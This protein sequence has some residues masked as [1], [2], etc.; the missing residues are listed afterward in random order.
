MRA[1]LLVAVGLMLP[2]AVQ[3]NCS[4]AHPP[5]MNLGTYQGTVSNSGASNLTVNCTRNSNDYQISLDAG[6]G[7]GAT[8]AVR[9]LTGPGAAVLRYSL[10]QDPARA[11]VWGDHLGVDTVFGDGNVSTRVFTI[12][13]RIPA[14]QYV[15][16][17]TYKDVIASATRTFN[18]VAVVQAACLISATS[19]AFGSYSGDAVDA[20]ARLLV[21]C[22]KSTPYY[23]SLGPGLHADSGGQ[24]NA[25]NSAGDL[26]GYGLFRDAARVARWGQ[27]FHVDGLAGTGSGVAQSLTVYGR[28]PS[29]QSPPPGD[30]SDIV[31]ATVIY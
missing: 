4:L 22:S 24:T 15:V 20:T 1:R 27:A 26:L 2:L 5:D 18:V 6:T 21:T 17:G 9:M 10:F 16:P 31:I 13:P 25:G 12:Y 11:Q 28:I 8:S 29:G 23:V 7:N 14:G 19:M 30:Y 3:A